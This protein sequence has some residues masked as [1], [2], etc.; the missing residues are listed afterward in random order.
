MFELIDVNLEKKM[1]DALHFVAKNLRETG[2]NPKPVLLH[3]F[4]ISMTL[5]ELN[6]SED[7]IISSILHDLIEDTN[8]TYDDIKNEFGEKIANIVS[9]VSFNPQIDDKLE[10]AKEMFKKCHENGF[11]ALIVKCSDLLD[12]ITFVNL[13]EDKNKRDILCKKY[14][15]FLEMSKDIIGKEKIYEMLSRKLDILE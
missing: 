4:K 10:Q 11:D 2:H 14:S 9:A 13:V 7:I 3:S 15:L 8:I 6:Y 5:Y 1:D 12:N